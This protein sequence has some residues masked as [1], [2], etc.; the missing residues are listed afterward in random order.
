MEHLPAG[1]PACVSRCHSCG[2]RGRTS[3]QQVLAL[4]GANRCT[5]LHN[6]EEESLEAALLLKLYGICS[7]TTPAYGFMG[8][9][10]GGYRVLRDL[11]L[12]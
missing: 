12:R 3:G 5:L 1:H 6:K 2:Q 11:G 8:A 4:A 10:W 9:T 7:M